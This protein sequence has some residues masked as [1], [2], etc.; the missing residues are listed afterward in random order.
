MATSRKGGGRKGGSVKGSVRKRQSAKTQAFFALNDLLSLYEKDDET[1]EVVKARRVLSENG[2]KQR[3][4]STQ[5]VE[6]I[7]AAMA[8]VDVD[9]DGAETILAK[10]AK[11]LRAAKS[12]N[13]AG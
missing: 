2:F 12:G 5:E 7:K 10:L 6:R 11:E 4:S 13:V 3:A 1:P 8:E 9:A